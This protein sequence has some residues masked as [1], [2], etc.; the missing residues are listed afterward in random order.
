MHTTVAILLGFGSLVLQSTYGLPVTKDEVG[1]SSRDD[2]PVLLPYEEDPSYETTHGSTAVSDIASD[3]YVS[4]T[5]PRDETK[6]YCGDDKKHLLARQG[7]SSSGSASSLDFRTGGTGSRPRVQIVDPTTLNPPYTITEGKPED[8]DEEGEYPEYYLI[9]PN[10]E[11]QEHNQERPSGKDSAV[12]WFGINKDATGLAVFGAFNADDTINENVNK[13]RAADM[14]LGFWEKMTKKP[15]SA[16]QT[17]EIVEMTNKEGTK[18]LDAALKELKLKDVL[19]VDDLGSREV[20]LSASSANAR[21]RAA[22]EI[23]KSGKPWGTL[24]QKITTGFIGTENLKIT[25]FVIKNKYLPGLVIH[26]ST[27]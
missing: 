23:V 2:N 22:F 26:F 4:Q 16:L 9:W 14:V 13:V 1:S 17:I 19:D 15:A 12:D 6:S 27:S 21:E 8:R 20:T 25:K 10:E 11:I 18:N 7:K 24:A 5:H 3:R